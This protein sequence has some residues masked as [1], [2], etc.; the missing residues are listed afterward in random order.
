MLANHL[1][2]YHPN[3]D[4]QSYAALKDV[5]LIPAL[6]DILARKM[7]HHVFLHTTASDIYNQAFIENIA[8]HL[9]ANH[10]PLSLSKATLIALTL[11]SLT[12]ADFD[13]EVFMNNFH[14]IIHKQE[15]QFQNIIL[16]IDN[17]DFINFAAAK[18]PNLLFNPQ[19]KII[20]TSSQPAL[21]SQL[22]TSLFSKLSLSEV[23]QHDANHIL[24]GFRQHLESFHH[25]IIPEEL[26]SLT[27]GLSNQYLNTQE[28]LLEKSLKL[29]D[30]ASARASMLE[31]EN[32]TGHK[33]IVTKAILAKVISNLT[34]IPL[35]HLQNHQFKASRFVS[36]L[37][38]TIFGQ[39]PALDLIGLTLQHANLL[40]QDK[41][42]PLCS[43][44]LAGPPNVGKS[45][46]AM[47]IAEHLFGHNKAFYQ[48]DYRPSCHHLEDVTVSRQSDEYHSSLF[49][50]IQHNPSAVIL[51]ENI[52][53]QN[54]A[55]LDIFSDM[56]TFG[57]VIDRHGKKYDFRHA[58]IVI[59]T[60]LGSDKLISLTQTLPSQDTSST[61]DLIQL[62]LNVHRQEPMQ[63]LRQLSPQELC[64]EM[65]PILESHLSS[66]LLRQLNIIPFN[67]LD[68]ASLEKIVK[69]KLKQFAARLQMQFNVELS[70]APEVIRFLTQEILWQGASKRSVDKTLQLYLHTC[71]AHELAGHVDDKN[72]AKRL[73]LQLNDSGQVLR[74]EFL[75]ASDGML[76]NI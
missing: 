51:F 37:Q 48:I 1:K 26:F 53:A 52:D 20:L 43:F 23:S 10:L 72:R 15:T 18:L 21:F 27:L 41:A 4:N 49:S 63:Q 55:F 57:Y 65:L 69:L 44:L 54:S 9:M 14:E 39:E 2:I 62:V 12:M 11:K 70:Y 73:L 46:C 25:V 75:Q 8:L 67:M 17:I 38:K 47:A 32:Q 42:G 40:F 59:T 56:F 74:C 24:K 50:A 61:L 76:Y 36:E 34:Q 71:V 13:N 66:N 22:D 33:P 19:F 64:V 68:F 6:F 7:S 3:I 30:S 58:I 60:T 45:R 16:I 31:K 28:P 29:L 35:S 5:T